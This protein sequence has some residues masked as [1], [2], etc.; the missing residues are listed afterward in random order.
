MAMDDEDDLPRAPKS[1]LPKLVLD[2][3]GIAELQSYIAEL[4]EEIVRAEAEITRKQGHRG[5]ADAIFRR[6]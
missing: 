3:L 2:P 1:R 5:A 6:P 4:K